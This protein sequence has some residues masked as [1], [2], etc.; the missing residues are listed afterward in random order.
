MRP[1]DSPDPSDP[2][3]SA[4]SE[5]AEEGQ[6]R[7]SEIEDLFRRHND[8]LLRFLVARIGSRQEAKD[9]AQEA[10][11]KLL[12]LDAPGTVSYLR[13][14]LYQTA[15]NLAKDRL[16]QR[17][18]RERIDSLVFFDH[19]AESPS[20]EPVCDAR[21]RLDLIAR[22]VEGLPPLCR[23]AFILRRFD[24]LSVEEV[25]ARLGVN[26]NE[27]RMSWTTT[28]PR[29]NGRPSTRSRTPK[30]TFCSTQTGYE[31]AVSFW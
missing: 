14:Y 15:A 31:K 8:S 25:A 19:T 9:V 7:S 23:A 29:A 12:A 10:Y 18:R 30:G 24:D 2:L 1:A 17:A 21:Q 11:V 6:I 3:A 28:C 16:K 5:A 26:E 22:A 13:A 27:P 20:P 4:S